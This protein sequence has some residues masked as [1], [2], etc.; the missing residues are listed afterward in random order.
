[1]TTEPIPNVAIQPAPATSPNASYVGTSWCSTRCVPT[2]QIRVRRLPS[3][4]ARRSPSIH[5]SAVSSPGV[6]SRARVAPVVPSHTM[7]TPSAP[8][9]ASSRP[10]G[11]NATS[12]AAAAWRS[13]SCHAVSPRAPSTT[14]PDG[15]TAAKRS[16][17]GAHT[18]A[19][20]RASSRPRSGQRRISPPVAAA[21][22]TISPDF[23]T[24]TSDPSSGASS[25]RAI[26]ATV[27][28]GARVASDHSSTCAS[29]ETMYSRVPSADSAALVTVGGGPAASA[30][31]PA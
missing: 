22:R 13:S 2:R 30:T 14:R 15:A 26:S 16:L 6:V 21:S 29:P 1:M 9:V 27:H 12:V 11:E 10:S 25:A 8:V 31:S 20:A 19:L 18:I 23:A 17:S 3:V 7:T 28:T 24:A 4:A 5:A